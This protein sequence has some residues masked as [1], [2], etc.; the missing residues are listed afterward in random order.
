MSQAYFPLYASKIV[1]SSDNFIIYFF[2]T[3]ILK[4]LS[5]TIKIFFYLI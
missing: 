2:K 3:K 1:I 4:A 5:S